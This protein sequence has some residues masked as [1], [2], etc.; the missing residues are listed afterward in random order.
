MRPDAG[1]ERRQPGLALGR[2]K[3]AGAQFEI[4]EQQGRRQ[5]GQ[6]RRPAGTDGIVDGNRLPIG[7]KQQGK[8]TGKEQDKRLAKAQ[9]QTPE[10]IA[11]KS[12]QAETDQQ[13]RLD[14]G[15]QIDVIRQPVG[16]SG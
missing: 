12:Q 4:A 3:G 7:K 8:A 13:Q 10:P 14:D 2:R 6:N 16:Q 11:G 5:H 15:R 1:V 9:R